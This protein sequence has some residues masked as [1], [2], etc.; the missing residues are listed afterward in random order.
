MKQKSKIVNIYFSKIWNSEIATKKRLSVT[1]K[2][3][4]IEKNYMTKN[5]F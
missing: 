4:K 3:S 2:I 1:S 5:V